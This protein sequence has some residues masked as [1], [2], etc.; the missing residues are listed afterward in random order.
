M[1]IIESLNIAAQVAT[2]APAPATTVTIETMPVYGAVAHLPTGETIVDAKAKEEEWTDNIAENGLSSNLPFIRQLD[3]LETMRKHWEVTEMAA[4]HNRLYAILT[5]CYAYYYKMKDKDTA[6]E[7]REMMKAG[8]DYFAK[9][10]ASVVKADTND[11]NRV[12]KAVFGDDRRRVSAY[13]LALR[14]AYDCGVLPSTLADWIKKKGGVEECRKEAS[15]TKSGI[16]LKERAAIAET[17]VKNTA[18]DIIKTDKLSTLFNGHDHDKMVVLVA[19]YRPTGELEIQGVV[20]TDSAVKAALSAYYSAN[21]ET[22]KAAATQAEIAAHTPMA[23][24]QS[25]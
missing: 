10:R 17:A 22:I 14:F 15:I 1:S 5:G 18:L 9:R 16:P 25:I 11:M 24:A 8:L 3:S 20:K 21:K 23:T 2:A 4:S 6:K 19:T 12:V 7:V 13:S